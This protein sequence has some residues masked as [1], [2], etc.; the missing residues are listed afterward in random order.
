MADYFPLSTQETFDHGGNLDVDTTAEAL[1]S[2]SV[3][4][5]IGVNVVADASNAG[6]IYIGNSDVSASAADATTGYPLSAGDA[7][8]LPISSPT[9]IYCIAS[10]VNQK[11]YWLAM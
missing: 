4:C 1:T 10:E 2:T 5:K 9:K 6:T 11:I 7:V 8:F 3:T